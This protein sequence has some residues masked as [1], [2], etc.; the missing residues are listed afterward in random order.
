MNR[1]SL[2]LSSSVI[3]ADKADAALADRFHLGFARGRW[4]SR[5]SVVSP[6]YLF[7]HSAGVQSCRKNINTLR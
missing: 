3:A 5:S 1:L 4:G 6:P 2:H 7:M